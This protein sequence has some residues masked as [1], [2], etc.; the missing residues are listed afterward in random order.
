MRCVFACSLQIL[1]RRSVGKNSADNSNSD[2]TNRFGS[3][4]P[5]KATLSPEVTLAC[6]IRVE[7]KLEEAKL[8]PT[9]SL[10]LDRQSIDKDKR[11]FAA[12]LHLPRQ[13]R[14]C[15]ILQPESETTRNRHPR[16]PGLFNSSI[17]PSLRQFCERAIVASFHTR[18]LHSCAPF[19]R[20]FKTE[21]VRAALSSTADTFK[22]DLN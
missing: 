15:C 2:P 6:R 18:H 20:P 5:A 8:L 14:G 4:A 3:R 21:R 1:G 19:Q 9:R 12:H 7:N 11:L 16:P 10:G 22:S 17:A 13:Q